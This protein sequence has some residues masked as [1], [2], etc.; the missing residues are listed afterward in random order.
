EVPVVNN[1]ITSTQSVTVTIQDLSGQGGAYNVGIANN[2]DSQLNGVN[3]TASPST[4]NVPAGGSTTFTVSAT[5]DGNVIRDTGTS[6]T[7]NGNQVA[8][9]PIEM[10]WYVTAQRSDGGENLRMPFYY[11][12]VFSRPAVSSVDTQTMQGKVLVGSLNSELST[13]QDYVDVPITIAPGTF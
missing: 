13:G 2:Q 4:V 6:Y 11:R 9:R 5:F 10:Q 7:T 8:F 1:R 3:V 12:P